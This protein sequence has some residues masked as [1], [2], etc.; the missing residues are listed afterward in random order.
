MCHIVILNIN[1]CFQI[2]FYRSFCAYGSVLVVFKIMGL[3]FYFVLI[4][5]FRLLTYNIKISRMLIC[6][7]FLRVTGVFFLLF[8]HLSFLVW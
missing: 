7:R 6:Y 4:Y 3:V 8:A 5:Y 1:K 2:Y